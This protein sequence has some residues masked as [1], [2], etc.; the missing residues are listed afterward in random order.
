MELKKFIEKIKVNKSKNSLIDL[1]YDILTLE[2]LMIES[3]EPVKEINQLG[4][5]LK[6]SFMLIF[7]NKVEINHKEIPDLDLEHWKNSI[8]KYKV[9][10]A[11]SKDVYLYTLRNSL[12]NLIKSCETKDDLSIKIYL[13]ELI[14]KTFLYIDY[15]DL[16]IDTIL[17]KIVKN[18]VPIKSI[19]KEEK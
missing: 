14:I 18:I 6:S 19:E 2:E 12:K 16:S 1:T 11:I 3:S 8:K 5:V 4:N 15:L 13:F 10:N 7:E 9:K 17:E